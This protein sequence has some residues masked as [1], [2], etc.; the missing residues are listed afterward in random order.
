MTPSSSQSPTSKNMLVVGYGQVPKA[1]VVKEVCDRFGWR[2]GL[3]LAK[4]RYGKE[5]RAMADSVVFYPNEDSELQ[6]RPRE[7]QDKKWSVVDAEIVE[8]FSKYETIMWP[9]FLRRKPAQHIKMGLDL[10]HQ[11]HKQITFFYNVFKEADIGV[12]LFSHMPHHFY[13]YMLYLYCQEFGVPTLVAIRSKFPNKHEILSTSFENGSDLIKLKIAD[14]VDSGSD[15]SLSEL[16]EAYI[17]GLMKD[18]DAAMPEYTRER[19]EIS[20]DKKKLKSRAGLMKQL[21]QPLAEPGIRR[22]PSDL[23]AKYK[24]I[25]G[26][27]KLLTYYEERAV[28]VDKSKPYILVCLHRQPEASNS[29]TGGTFVHQVMM[30]DILSR[31]IPEDWTIY[32]KE[33]P[34]QLHWQV[35]N[36]LFR[37]TAYYD[38]FLEIPKV[39]LLSSS[40]PVFDSID[41]AEAV[42]IVAGTTGWEAAVRGTPVLTFGA[43]WYRHCEGVFHVETLADCQ[44]AMESIQNGYQVDSQKVRAFAKA[45][46]EAGY[47]KFGHDKDGTLDVQSDDYIAYRA[48]LM[49]EQFN[50]LIPHATPQA[51]GRV[52]AESGQD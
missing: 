19:F 2:P 21:I 39:K 47:P 17:G 30:V 25:F 4:K 34:S 9:L 42:A 51:A 15:T 43:A 48:D 8:R 41:H 50:L 10:K 44:K 31:S 11:Y 16:N 32:V 37:T 49:Q 27:R 45:W 12:A 24:M 3:W 46:Q 1:R 22:S 52:E 28:A 26:R 23:Y 18:Y 35:Y 14:I 33:H 36:E 40:E 5:L 7:Y 13:S 29:P 6:I 38:D 20:A